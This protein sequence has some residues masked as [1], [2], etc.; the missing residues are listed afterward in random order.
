MNTPAQKKARKAQADF[1]RKAMDVADRTSYST[2]TQG[3]VI[4]TI[5]Y[6]NQDGTVTESSSRVATSFQGSRATFDAKETAYRRTLERM[7]NSILNNASDEEI[8]KMILQTEHPQI[9]VF[10]AL[11]KRTESVGDREML[12]SLIIEE[13]IVSH[14][15]EQLEKVVERLK[16]SPRTANNNCMDL[17]LKALSTPENED[18][19]AR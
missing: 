3:Y 18:E 7:V 2:D 12:I 15:G 8:E 5:K 14:A 1:V 6:Y 17:A 11:K 19:T 9:R 10:D 16:V 13:E 4:K